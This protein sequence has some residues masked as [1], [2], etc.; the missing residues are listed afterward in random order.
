MPTRT[1][2]DL[3]CDGGGVLEER[4]DLLVPLPLGVVQRRVAI[5]PTEKR[6]DG[7]EVEAAAAE[8]EGGGLW[9]ARRGGAA[10]TQGPSPPSPTPAPRPQNPPYALPPRPSAPSLTLS[11]RRASA[12]ALSSASTQGAWRL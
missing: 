2:A 1:R 8:G 4:D 10:P 9:V 11:L 7:A 5:L 6:G 12:P 3:R